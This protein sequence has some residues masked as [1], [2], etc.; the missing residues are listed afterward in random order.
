MEP[1]MSGNDAGSQPG[2]G[3]IMQKLSRMEQQTS[4]EEMLQVYSN[5]DFSEMVQGHNRMENERQLQTQ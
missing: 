2:S 5:S 4:C 1:Q 3:E